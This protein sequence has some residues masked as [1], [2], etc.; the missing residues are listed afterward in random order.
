MNKFIE[1]HNSKIIIVLTLIII[2]QAIAIASLRKQIEDIE[3]TA[4]HAEEIISD[5]EYKIEKN[6]IFDKIEDFENRIE[7]LESNSN[8]FIYSPS[9]STN[10]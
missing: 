2:S 9:F 3:Y 1:N 6:E 8:D 4:N 10:W 7:T 5:L